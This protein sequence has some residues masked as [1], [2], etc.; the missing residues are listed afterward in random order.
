MR[1]RSLQQWVAKTHPGTV[2]TRQWQALEESSPLDRFG[3]H[4]YNWIQRH[5]PILHHGYFS[6]LEK[7][8]LHRHSLRPKAR[9]RYREVLDDFQPDVLISVH[10][11]L[12]HAYFAEAKACLEKEIPCYTC[13]GEMHGGYGFSRHWVNPKANGFFAATQECAQAA[14]EL[15]L[16]AEKT[17]VSGFLLNPSFFAEKPNRRD[18]RASLF[19]DLQET[20]LVLL[21]TGANGANQ[22]EK[23]LRA[24]ARRSKSPGVVALCGKNEKTLQR[25]KTLIPRL[26]PLKV[27]PMGYQKDLQPL[28]HAAD[29][30][31][32][33]PG[34]GT[35]CEAIMS[36]CPVLFNG[37]GGIMPQEGITLKF[38]RKRGINTPQTRSIRD[39]AA[40]IDYLLYS[41]EGTS[42]L[43]N[44]RRA[45]AD[46]AKNQNPEALINRILP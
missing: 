24:L 43:D 4:L 1:A 45:F 29:L 6:F 14:Q 35:T 44:T 37:L 19:P 42:L 7:A 25:L 28:L 21:G 26:H 39:T 17:F 36:G 40:Q 18:L 12:N 33:R 13:C 2:E 32:I 46:L 34:T 41:K 30:A 27:Y 10:A 8:S 15:G 23:I 3:V 38:F 9:L 31:F 16:A 20:P 11:H 22:H 5:W